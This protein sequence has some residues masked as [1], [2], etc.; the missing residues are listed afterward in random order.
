M[1]WICV[2][3]WVSFCDY[4]FDGSMGVMMGFGLFINDYSLVIINGW[5]YLYEC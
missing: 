4:L 5:I 1:E 3:A 2:D